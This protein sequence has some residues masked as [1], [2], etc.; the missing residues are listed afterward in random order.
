MICVMP[1]ASG[2]GFLLHLVV[3]FALFFAVSWPLSFFL[4]RF[5]NRC[6]ET[7]ARY[8]ATPRC[9]LPPLDPL[10]PPIT[11]TAI[12]AIEAMWLPLYWLIWLGGGFVGAWLFLTGSVDGD[13]IRSYLFLVIPSL[14]GLMSLPFVAAEICCCA[15]LVLRDNLQKQ[16]NRENGATDPRSYFLLLRSFTREG[17]R[18]VG[19]KPY[20][21]HG[22]NGTLP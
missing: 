15:L 21:P 2:F 17:L 5:S 12:T 18:F 10:D 1:S 3:G 22:I 13:F 6:D 16:E 4:Q 14:L 8:L 7:L 9:H 11:S 19:Q 20:R